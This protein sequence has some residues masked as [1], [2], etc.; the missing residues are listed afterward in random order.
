MFVK[1]KF[2]NV[3][4]FYRILII[5]I[6]FYRF[7]IPSFTQAYGLTGATLGV[8]ATPNAGGKVGS[9]GKVLPGIQIKV[10]D[11]ETGK[12]VGP[13]QIGELIIKGPVVA[14]G[15]YGN[16]N[17]TKDTFKNGWL[18]SGDLGYYDEEGFFFIVDRLKDLIKYRGFQVGNFLSKKLPYNIWELI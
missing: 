7:K 4:I 15:Y 6:I 16:E 18:Y 1:G 11:P 3:S 10:R 13:N 17:A 14:K 2:Y 8:I 5:L 9:C 12:V